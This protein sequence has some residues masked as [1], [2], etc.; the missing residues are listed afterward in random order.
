MTVP[1]PLLPLGDRPIIDVLLAQ[2][3]AA[4]VT[5]VFVCLG[6]LAPLMMAFLGD[7]SR[8]GVTIEP[9]RGAE[10]TGTASGLCAPWTGSA[11]TSSW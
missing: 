2:L 4:G 5:R 8:W 7:G 10:R 9:P 1:K 3:A 11:T 6:Y